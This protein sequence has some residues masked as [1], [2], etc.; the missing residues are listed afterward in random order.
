MPFCYQ[1]RTRH[2]KVLIG[3]GSMATMSRIPV[4]APFFARVCSRS[5]LPLAQ[6]SVCRSGARGQ[7]VVSVAQHDGRLEQMQAS[8]K[9]A[10]ASD[11]TGLTARKGC[12]SA[13]R[14][15]AGFGV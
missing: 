15:R 13:G 9:A 6:G 14:G 11:L 4:I 7:D 8:Q 3:L 1:S 12:R 5:K 2:A 10:D